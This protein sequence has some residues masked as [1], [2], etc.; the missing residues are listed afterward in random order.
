MS[1]FDELKKLVKRIAGAAGLERGIIE[2]TTNEKQ[3]TKIVIRPHILVR[4]TGKETWELA[5]PTTIDTKAGVDVIRGSKELILR[6]C[7]SHG[8]I[9]AELGTDPEEFSIT[10]RQKR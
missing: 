6:L 9:R 1:D 3:I 4:S 5:L 7:G 2:I 10:H 8:S